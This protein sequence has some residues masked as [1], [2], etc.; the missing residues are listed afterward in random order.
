MLNVEYKNRIS[1]RRHT[2]AGYLACKTNESQTAC[3]KVKKKSETAMTQGIS[4][5]PGD[6]MQYS[7]APT[8]YFCLINPRDHLDTKSRVQRSRLH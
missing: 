5:P 4:V 1:V 3:T 8:L 6:S 2:Q 7:V